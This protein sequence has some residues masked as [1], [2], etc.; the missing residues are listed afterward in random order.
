MYEE[1]SW[2]AKSCVFESSKQEKKIY[3]GTKNKIYYE[4][5]TDVRHWINH[6]IFGKKN[7]YLGR[8]IIYLLLILYHPS[9][10]AEPKKWKNF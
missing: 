5:R 7:S 2:Y 1:I 9:N 6:P 4:I 8:L 3:I 10:N